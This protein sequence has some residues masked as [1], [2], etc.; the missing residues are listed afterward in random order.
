MKPDRDAAPPAPD[1]SRR[2]ALRRMACGALVPLAAPAAASLLTPLPKATA[3]SPL[4]TPGHTRCDGT[5]SA[6]SGSLVLPGSDPI[7]V[8]KAMMSIGIGS[9]PVVGG[10]L[11]VIFELFWPVDGRSAWEHVKDEVRRMVDQAI[12]TEV[13]TQL[14]LT[15]D[16]VRG[17]LSDHL[18][19]IRHCTGPNAK[20]EDQA[21]ILSSAQTLQQLFS[22]K[23][24]LFKRDASQ[25]TLDGRC[26]V[27]PLYVQVANLH[28]AFLG[29]TAT[30][31]ARYG[32]S[33][34]STGL[35]REYFRNA[36][37]EHCAYVDRALP[38]LFNELEA[39]YQSRR[40][41]MREDTAPGS[42]HS[43]VAT[44]AWW[45]KKEQ[46][47]RR[48]LLITCV[49]DYRALWPHIAGNTARPAP[50]TRE[51]V[52]GPYGAPDVADIGGLNGHYP[53]V[54]PAVV[55]P[56]RPIRHVCV[57]QI[58]V[59]RKKKPSWRFP[60][61]FEVYREGDGHTVPGDR[62]GISL[63]PKYGGNVVGMRVDTSLYISR[64][65]NP[66][67]D[68]PC[69]SGWLVTGVYFTQEDGQTR[70]VGSSGSVEGEI[71]GSDGEDVPVPRGHRLWEIQQTSTVKQLYRNI[72][73]NTESVGSVMFAFRL[74]DPTLAVPPELLER[75]YVASPVELGVNDLVDLDQRIMAA[76]GDA[77]TP[78]EKAALRTHLDHEIAVE[79]LAADRAAFWDK[80]EREAL[81]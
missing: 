56:G 52:L 53:D 14:G 31:A 80:I 62:F 32:F 33:E 3:E 74:I 25:L 28:L 29:D 39:R 30:H 49:E 15:I 57:P 16:G 9:I 43:F 63:D 42:K 75:L 46:N 65:V 55:N 13:Q 77:P 54:P 66:L 1:A 69:T 37:A 10:A 76:R 61:N 38:K 50:L 70:S 71:K 11:A 18:A 20:P 41:E 22:L 8:L 81:D 64:T 47:L 60:R 23:A 4:A 27:L 59:A 26:Q 35:F 12:D 36:I 78:A 19:A 44:G 45:G 5:R 40:S 58:D 72:G 73:E 68:M 2:K 34:A 7:N 21:L 17:A 79:Q 51:I 24:P 48:A 67:S 6:S